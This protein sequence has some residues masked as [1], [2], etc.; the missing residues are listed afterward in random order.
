MTGLRRLYQPA[1]RLDLKLTLAPLGRGP[2]DASARWEGGSFHWATRTPAGPGTLR[3]KALPEGV[4]LEAWGPGAEALLERAPRLLGAADDPSGF[5]PQ[6]KLRA[7]QRRFAGLRLCAS[8]A[9][10][11]AAV[12]AVLE[13]LVS[14]LEAM[15]SWNALCRALGEPAPGPVRLHLPPA[16]AVLAAQPLYAFPPFGVEQ[17]R[18]RALKAVAK[19]AARL[20]APGLSR[21]ALRARLVALPGVGPWTAAQVLHE[22]TGDPDAISVG[23]YNLKHTVV[24]AFTGAPRGTDEEM[25][26]LLAPFAGH[27]ARVVR[28]IFAA[29]IT[30]PRFGPRHALRRVERG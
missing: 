27:R 21:E 30:A 6:G 23:D 19:A 18:A 17:K 3:L 2:H 4:E 14:G 12:R 9:V 20:D 11:E 26:E 13:Q 15:R 10:Y 16:P 25:L 8:G 28:L 24:F 22:A 29:G 7:L 5:A 1:G